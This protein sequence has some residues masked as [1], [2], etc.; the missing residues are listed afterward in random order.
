MLELNYLRKYKEEVVKALDKRNLDACSLV[1][2]ILELDQQK[3]KTQ[4]EMDTQ[5]ATM[6]SISRSIG[7][8]IKEGKKESVEQ[9]KRE[10]AVFKQEIKE[11]EISLSTIEEN[12]RDL[13]V[14]L[15]NTPHPLVSKGI[16]EEDNEV[17]VQEGNIMEGSNLMPHWELAKKYDLMDFDLGAK[18]SG[19]GFVVRKGKGAAF[20]RGLIQ[21]FLQENI[22]AGYTEYAPPFVVNETSAFGTGQLP[23]KENQMYHI[24]GDNLFLIPTS[25]VPLTNL[26]RDSLLEEKELPIKMTAYSPCFRREA[27]SYG[28]HVRGLNRLH[29]FEKVELVR[30]EKPEDS[31]Q[32]LDQMVEHVKGLLTK[33]ELP[34][35]ILRLCGGDLGFA[36]A[37]TYDFE[38]YSP[39]QK[40]WLEVSSVSNFETF[41]SNRLKLRYRTNENKTLLCHT[42]NGS[43]LALPRI[44]ATLLENHQTE[45]GIKVPEALHPYYRSEYISETFEK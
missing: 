33:L 31:Y 11:K 40:R 21:F 38:A 15:P 8:L 42:L 20:Q 14:Q 22:E 35:R 16:T 37:M 44:V 7:T 3:R 13:L 2:K 24:T 26:Y 28:S 18:V 27:G 19:S 17:I 10:T 39:A 29:Q 30:I 4:F 43:S 45:K 34:F 32:A 36:S 23:D 5:K 12:L 1:E 9:K 25:E 6:N 41:Q